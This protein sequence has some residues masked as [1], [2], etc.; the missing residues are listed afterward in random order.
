MDAVELPLPVDVSVVPKLMGSEGFVRAGVTVKEV[1]GRGS[2]RVSIQVNPSVDRCISYLSKKEVAIVTTTTESS[3][4]DHFPE[5]E[6]CKN[7]SQLPNIPSEYVAKN[8][9]SM[10]K[11]CPMITS[12]P[13]VA[14][15]QRKAGKATK[16][17]ISSS[18][19]LRMSQAET[20]TSLTVVEERKDMSDKLRLDPT[21][22]TS[23]EKN[24]LVKQ[25][26]NVNSKRG[27]KRSFKLSVKTKFDSSS[28]KLGS[29]SFSSASGGNSLFGLYGLKSDFHDV[30]KLVEDP[31]LNELLSGTYSCPALSKDKGKKE[32][33]TNE[34]F[35]SSV[36]RA[37]SILQVP[38]SVQSQNIAEMDSYSNKKMSACQLNLV[39]TIESGAN[40][41]NGQYS[42]TEASQCHKDSCN[43][44]ET[45]C[46]SLDFP[47]HQPKDV[48]GRI[49]LPPP[50]DLESLLLDA[51]KPAGSTKNTPDLRAGKQ[52]FRWPSLP[53]FPW[54]HA[55]GGHSRSNSDAVKLSASKS[56]CH[57]RWARIGNIASSVGIAGDLF[58]NL[59]S[60]TYDQSLVPSGGPKMGSSDNKVFLSL[61]ANQS[62]CHQDSSS[63]VF[64]RTSQVT[65]ESGGQWNNQM[66]DGHC[67]RLFAAAQ[68]LY[69]MATCALRNPD[70]IVRWQ[71]RPSQ[72]TIKGRNL[73]S[74]VK[75]EETLG[76]PIPVIESDLV[77]SMEQVIPSKKRRL[78]TAGKKVGGPSN[79]VKRGPINWPTSR[80]SR[81]LHCTSVRDSTVETKHSTGSILK[82][83]CIM[84]PPAR[85]LDK[86][87]DNQQTARKLVS[88]DWKRGR[89][90]PE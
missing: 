75:L 83:S 37:F 28:M 88:M 57:G 46:I 45:A 55:F 61:F 16:S 11:R 77:R 27:D 36:K 1:G 68:T 42:V 6:F 70:G 18:K 69:E 90:K 15:L 58:T 5:T 64:S 24:Q 41:D 53:P 21:K 17:S 84:P 74:K 3:S 10:D 47:I 50:R 62:F 63:L 89:N 86:P 39:S 59:D 81:S 32:A 34:K 66:T 52:I 9:H 87:C 54:S 2:D 51:N 7:S 31:P 80:P 78:S 22:C 60:L 19:R 33:N 29:S 8:V 48:L 79:C 56:I 85:I 43:E 71:K 14:R 23:A 4:W 26:S 30:T 12:V 35:F 13:E 49:A 25:K 67:P 65:V 73:K 20:S 82:Q 44:A 76:T 40:G 72:K 38:K